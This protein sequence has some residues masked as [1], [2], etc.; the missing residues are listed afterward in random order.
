MDELGLVQI[1]EIGSEMLFEIS[2]PRYEFSSRLV[3][4]NLVFAE[5]TEVLRSERLTGALLDRLTQ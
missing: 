5:W 4:S 1:S 3:T 2:G